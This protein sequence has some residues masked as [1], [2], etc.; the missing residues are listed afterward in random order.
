[1][2]DVAEALNI[3]KGTKV[4]LHKDVVIGNAGITIGHCG[5]G[6]DINTSSGAAYDLDFFMVECGEDNKAQGLGSV[7][8]YNKREN[9]N[10]S[11]YVLED[12]LTGVG[13]GFDEEGFVKFADVPAG[14]KSIVCCVSIY[15]YATRRQNFGQVNNAVCEVLDG[16]SGAKLL[17]YDLTEDMS[18]ATGV[19]VGRFMRESDGTWSFKAVGETVNGGMKEIL[20][21]Y[22]ITI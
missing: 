14:I 6:W 12:N 5:L 10:R 3:T 22:G 11:V 4:N 16:V 1:M 13:S 15:D 8:F 9:A 7:I 18:S 21:K 17:K 19:V 2:V 20:A